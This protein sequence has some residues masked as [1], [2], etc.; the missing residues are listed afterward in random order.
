MEYGAKTDLIAQTARL[1]GRLL[2]ENG[3]ETYRVEHT[4][5]YICE[6]FAL[7]EVSL[8]SLPTATL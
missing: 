5:R 4:L 6:S 1:A 3:A 8:L 2:L 7:T